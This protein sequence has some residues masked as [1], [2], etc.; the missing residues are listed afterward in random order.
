M[1]FGE[2]LMIVAANG[3]LRGLIFFLY[4]IRINE[5]IGEGGE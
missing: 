2:I 4:F 1:V 3:N 5:V